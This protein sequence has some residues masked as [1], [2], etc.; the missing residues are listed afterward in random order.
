MPPSV[1]WVSI[2][3]SSAAEKSS[4][5][6]AS[7]ESSSCDTERAPISAEVTR[8]SRSTQAMAICASV[9]P[10][11][12][13]MASSARMRP[14]FSSVTRLD[15]KDPP[16]AARDPSGTPPRY[17]EV[18]SPCASGEKAM[19]PVPISCSTSSRPSST[20]RFSME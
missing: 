7:S 2:A 1:A 4:V 8:G 14:T 15:E 5:F 12:L 11:A 6:S 16:L 18:S 9:W 13:A 19:Q 3:D 17:F 10:R 20:Q